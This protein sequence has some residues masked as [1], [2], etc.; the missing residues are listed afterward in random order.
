M[1]DFDRPV[2]TGCSAR[3][4]GHHDAQTFRI[5]TLPAMSFTAKFLSGT[6]RSG[7]SKGGAALPMSG[8]GTSRGLRPRPT[9][10]RITSAQNAMM[11][12]A[13]L[14]QLPLPFSFH[15]LQTGSGDPRPRGS[16]RAP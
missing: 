4:G 9:A 11:A 2:T 16:R 12:H 15:V 6:A 10:S 3:H 14:M 8:E 7:S 5:H 13:T 1:A